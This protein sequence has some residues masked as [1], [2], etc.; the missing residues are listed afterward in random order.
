MTGRSKPERFT[1]AEWML[2]PLVYVFALCFGLLIW[3][4]TRRDMGRWNHYPV[5]WS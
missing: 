5:D 3:L 2:L 4:Q 1:L